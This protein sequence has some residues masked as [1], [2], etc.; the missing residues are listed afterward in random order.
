MM[1][2]RKSTD[3]KPLGMGLA[4]HVGRQGRESFVEHAGSGPG[5]DSLLRLYPKRGLLNRRAWKRQW[6]RARRRLRI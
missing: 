6:L 1:R 3:G 5:I 2:M 4:W